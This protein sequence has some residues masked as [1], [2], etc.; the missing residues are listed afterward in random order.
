MR[1]ALPEG[2]T[3]ERCIVHW[4]WAT[5]NSCNPP[6]YANYS[7][8]R[9]WEGLPGDGA[10]T[11]GI[12][13][14]FPECG[15]SAK[16]F[17]EEFW[18]CSENIVIKPRRQ[19]AARTK[20]IFHDGEMNIEGPGDSSTHRPGVIKPSQPAA[21]AAP[22]MMLPSETGASSG[23]QEARPTERSRAMDGKASDILPESDEGAIAVTPSMMPS[24]RAAEAYGDQKKTRPT[25]E[26][27][28]GAEDEESYMPPVESGER[29]NASKYNLMRYVSTFDTGKCFRVDKGLSFCQAC[30]DFGHGVTKCMWCMAHE[31]GRGECYADMPTHL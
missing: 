31:N 19:R 16:A 22:S 21:S 15:S 8:P 1:Y 28:G 23:E 27:A 7:F 17:P 29:R 14:N 25:E 18:A 20:Q 26:S 4:Y 5:A 9:R 12:N 6:G 30:L 13:T 2:V 11:G 10:S 3:C 24:Q